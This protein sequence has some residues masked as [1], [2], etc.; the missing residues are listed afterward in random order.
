[1]VWVLAP[2]VSDIGSLQEAAA[3]LARRGNA[4]C[5]RRVLARM[6]ARTPTAA[7][8]LNRLRMC[9]A[10]TAGAAMAAVPDADEVN[11]AIDEWL[12]EKHE[13]S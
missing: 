7:A 8:E 6:N 10:R 3:A 12:V 9:A 11:R 2:V 13:T 4:V 5:L 1:M